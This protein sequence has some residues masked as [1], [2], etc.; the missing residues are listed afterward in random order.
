MTEH[1]AI[2]FLKNMQGE[3]NGRAIGAEGFYAELCGYHVQALGMGIKA[4][5]QIETIKEI[6][7]SSLYIQEDVLRYK[8]ICKVFESED[9]E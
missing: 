4:L 8:M 6:I 2:Q 7:N 5:K 9:K 3:E 1:E